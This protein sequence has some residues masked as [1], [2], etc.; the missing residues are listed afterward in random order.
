MTE[1]KRNHRLNIEY[2]MTDFYKYYKDNKTEINK[3]LGL[4]E[5]R[6]VLNGLFSKIR[7]K[8]TSDVYDYKLPRRLGVIKIRKFIKIVKIDDNGKMSHRL[9]PNW[10]ATKELW[11]SDPEMKAQKKIIFHDNENTNG[12]TFK[13]V[14]SKKSANFRGQ[15]IYKLKPCRRFTR[16]LSVNITNGKFD[17]FLLTN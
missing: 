5:Y 16:N 10:K 17:T 7:D 2:G 14:Y 6:K 4:N 3:P 1:S 13:I 11:N 9:A 15:G 12:Y 8:M